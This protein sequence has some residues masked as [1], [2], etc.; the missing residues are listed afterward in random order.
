MPKW[1][2]RIT[3]GLGNGV[4][5]LLV[6][7]GI[8]PK[9][10]FVDKNRKKCRYGEPVIFVGNHISHY[11]GLMT[12][13]EF[14]K[15]DAHILVAKDWY[16]KKSVNWYLKHAKC[17]PMDRHGIDT[18]WLRMSKDAIKNKDSVII[19][20]EGKTG[21]DGV[22]NE[23][24]SGFVMLALMTGAKIVPFASYGNYK[25]FF[26]RR[27]RMLVGEP[28]EL[29]A[30]GKGMNPAYMEAESERFKNIVTDLVNTLKGDR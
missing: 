17:I 29:S 5:Y 7:A 10:R 1:F 24:K 15:A 20:P 28:T 27:Q 12:S 21:K 22:L 18:N 30:E 16:E 6:K 2:S 23:F 4:I 8:R 13:V 25:L 3:T 11:D 14:R 9:V 26:G 19:Y